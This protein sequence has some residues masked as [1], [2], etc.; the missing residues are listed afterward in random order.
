MWDLIGDLINAVA[1]LWWTDSEMRDSSPMTAG[2][3][4]DRESRRFV[5]LLCGGVIILLLIAGLL[6]WWFAQ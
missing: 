6:W 4:F 2:S 5:A 3:Q 1:Q